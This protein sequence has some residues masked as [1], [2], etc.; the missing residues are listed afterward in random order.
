MRG[1]RK[2]GRF[3]AGFLKWFMRNA[4]GTPVWVLWEDSGVRSG[5]GTSW[6]K[7]VRVRRG[8]TTLESVQGYLLYWTSL[9]G[10]MIKFIT[11]KVLQHSTAMYSFS[12]I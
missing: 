12:Y 4:G 5:R 10:E 11:A 3:I 9:L 2:A 7:T 8:A 6:I 1:G